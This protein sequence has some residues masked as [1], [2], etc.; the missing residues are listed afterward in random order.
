MEQGYETE[1]LR[2][3]DKGAGIFEP[4]TVSVRQQTALYSYQYHVLTG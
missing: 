3:L 1:T 2:L 4:R